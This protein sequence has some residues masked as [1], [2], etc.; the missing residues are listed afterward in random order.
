MSTPAWPAGIS[1]IAQPSSYRESGPKGNVIRT[2]ME[3]GPAKS[4]RRFTAAVRHISGNTDILTDAQVATF[5]TWF[6]DTI[7]DGALA[8]TATNPRTGATET[9]RFLKEYDV[10]HIDDDKNRLALTL[11]KLP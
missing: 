3:N 1:F 10:L 5:D 11:E 7:D 8:F 9:Y 4:R 6:T 2:D